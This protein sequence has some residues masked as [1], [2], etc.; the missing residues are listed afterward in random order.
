MRHT[1]VPL[2]AS[3][4]PATDLVMRRHEFFLGV[5]APV[6]AHTLHPHTAPKKV[7]IVG[8]GVLPSPPAT[9]LPSHNPKNSHNAPTR[10]IWSV[11]ETN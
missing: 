6:R 2:L 10:A 4:P 3:T 8:L 9:K 5:V 1:S 7:V 11:L